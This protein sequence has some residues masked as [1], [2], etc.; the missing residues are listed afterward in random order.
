VPQ[1]GSAEDD[2]GG[3]C[4]LTRS[5]AAVDGLP[6]VIDDS[7]DAGPSLAATLTLTP[8]GGDKWLKPCE[9]NFVFAPHFDFDKTWNDWPGLNNWEK[10]E[11]GSGGCGRFQRAA[12]DLVRQTQRDRAGA[13]SHFLA[14][15]TGPQREAYQRLKRGA[16][17]PDPD[18][19]QADGDD[20][21][22][23]KTAAGLT[24]T[25]PLLLP[26]LV[27]DHVY[28]A[29]VGH[30]TIGWRVFSDWKVTVETEDADTTREIARFAIGMTPGLIVS[31]IVK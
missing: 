3:S 26:M 20:A 1:P 11:C 2:I 13:E 14:A 6:V 19:A 4:G 16:D 8:W 24:E 17:R 21:P 29:S 7:L 22:K 28:L 10:N 25:S 15:L 9:A 12:L 27:D 18:S 31:V 23:P 5:F 30:F